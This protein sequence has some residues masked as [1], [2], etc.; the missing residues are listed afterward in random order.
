MKTMM[1]HLLGHLSIFFTLLP[2]GCNDKGTD[3]PPPII[4]EKK[5]E[6]VAKFKNI[7]IRYMVKHN[8]ILYVSTYFKGHT[9]DD[10]SEFVL[11]KTEDGVNWE[12]M[13][14]FERYIGPIAFHG[15]TLTILESGRT[16][17]YH[18]SFGWKMFWKHSIAADQTYDMFWLNNE[19]F[20]YANRI[21][22][23]FSE[24]SVRDLFQPPY[25]SKFA[26]NIL[27]SSHVVYTR[28]FY[29][30]EDKI[31]R[32]NGVS[33]EVIMNGISAN[34]NVRANYPSMYVH[35]D[36]LYAGFNTPSRI[37]KLVND[38]WV[39]IT[40]TIPN[41]PYENISSPPLINRPTA[42]AFHQNTLFVG[43]EWMGVLQWTDSGW[44]SISKGLRL[45]FP[46]YPQY[47]LYIAIVQLESFNGKLFVAYGEPFYAPGSGKG[48]GMYYYN[49]E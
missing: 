12:V 37:K 11:Y 1:L 46:D 47:E 19:L 24:D 22:Q 27:S 8:G 29:V 17:K 30:Y 49:V 28:P 36:T 40:D 16:W 15:D 34:E 20:V 3:P 23:V 6:E 25:Y 44:V 5:W 21:R 10:T 43:T 13:K 35:N 4:E 18:S 7:D 32:F 2:I 9:V 45:E 14:A 33:S 38:F 48:K 26:K 39:N 42:I 31:Y 41:T